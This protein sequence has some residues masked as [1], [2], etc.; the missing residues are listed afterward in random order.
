MYGCDGK[1]NC[2]F[3][4]ATSILC[5]V[6][7]IFR[8]DSPLIKANAAAIT[9]VYKHLGINVEFS[10]ER[11]SLLTT[12]YYVLAILGNPYEIT[13]YIHLKAQSGKLVDIYQ[14]MWGEIQSCLV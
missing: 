2:M 13:I 10:I 3:I 14:S 11:F 9:K 12:S 6:L 1:A 8:I 4:I 5:Q 7:N